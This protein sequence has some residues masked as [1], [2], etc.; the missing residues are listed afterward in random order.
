M[1]PHI[2]SAVIIFNPTKVIFSL[3]PAHLQKMAPG[4]FK[5]YFKEF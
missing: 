5:S 3:P 4:G 1:Y 2:Q